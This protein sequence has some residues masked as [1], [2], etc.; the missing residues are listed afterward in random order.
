[1][2]S[3]R[4][5]PRRAARVRALLRSSRLGSTLAGDMTLLHR[6]VVDVASIAL[7]DRLIITDTFIR[8]GREG[9]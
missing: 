6:L 3:R 4:A 1:V 7:D 9:P 2:M 8:M 5:A